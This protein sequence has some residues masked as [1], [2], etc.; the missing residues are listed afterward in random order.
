M[1]RNVAFLMLAAM[2]SLIV[3]MA[4]V[5]AQELANLQ[6]NSSAGETPVGDLALELVG[7]VINTPP[8]ASIQ[9]GYL[10]Y[11]RG[12]DQIFNPNA[13]NETTARFTFFTE[14]TTTRTIANGPFRI[15]TREG[16]TT[17]YFDPSANGNFATPDSFR[18]GAPILTAT[19]RQQVI[20]DTTD[21]TFTVVNLNTVIASASFT[22]D[23]HD[24]QIAK[25]GQKFRTSLVGRLNSP[26]P[27]TGYFA[28]FAVD[29][30]PDPQPCNP[31]LRDCG[32]R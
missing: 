14:A 26:S 10:A 16:T 11:L 4:P 5:S 32:R 30:E 6:N 21:Q 15:I 17:V 3:M 2:V 7:Q 27:P 12:V 29:V 19:L 8:A 9:F 13:H 28:G 20:L 25:R 22:L 23:G 31:F 18:D 24:F 1:T